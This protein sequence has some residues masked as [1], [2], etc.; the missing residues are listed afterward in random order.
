MSV[1]SSPIKTAHL[2]MPYG[3]AMHMLRKMIV[4]H[5]AQR[6]KEDFCFKCNQKIETVEE[7]SIE[8]K[9]P[10]LHGDQSLFWS[11]DNIAFSHRKCNRPERLRG[12][13]PQP[14]PNGTAWCIGCQT[15]VNVD[16][17]WKNRTRW[18]GLQTYCRVCITKY[19]RARRLQ[20]R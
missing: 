6:L 13:Q 16:Q 17:F 20:Q 8:H 14:A 15:F 9:I 3:T 10:W 2:G 4:F 18:N 19:S 1:N 5:M 12:K 11:M 7:L